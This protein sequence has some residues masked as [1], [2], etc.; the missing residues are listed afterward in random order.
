MNTMFR[1]LILLALTWV[2]TS[3]SF[4]MGRNSCVKERRGAFDIGSGTTKAVAVEV[5]TCHTPM[6]TI[7]WEES[8]AL[9]LKE[10]LLK[11]NKLSDEI[12]AEAQKVIGDLLQQLREHG[13]I[14]VSGV[15]TMALRQAPNGA[16]FLKSLGRKFDLPLRII[17]QKEEAALGAMSARTLR[18]EVASEV[19]WDIGGASAQWVY[20]DQ[21]QTQFILS[22]LASVSFKDQVLQAT[23][24]KSAQ[25]SSPN[26][27]GKE[28]L[29]KAQQ[30]ARS[31]AQSFS[32]NLASAISKSQ[33]AVLGIGGVHRFSVLGNLQKREFIAPQA[34]SY[35]REQLASAIKKSY[36]LN[37]EQIG[38]EFAATDVTNLVLVYSQM[39][40]LGISQ[41]EVAKGNLALGVVMQEMLKSYGAND[42]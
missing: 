8:R 37:D 31:H 17:T 33:G 22:D 13:V 23:K 42:L 40:A 38:G 16:E 11:N 24:K 30:I 20:K 34:Q 1:P 2:L 3:C 39:S 4:T 28:G 6:A 9:G 27:L 35:T 5:N 25:V 7:L 18:P 36:Q 41:V 10:D 26:P 21:G 19:I 14:H 29:L 32:K 15:G 12:Y